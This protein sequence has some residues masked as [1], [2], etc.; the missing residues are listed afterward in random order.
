MKKLLGAV[1][2][3]LL[4]FAA[5]ANCN[6]RTFP[7]VTPWV[8]V[9]E[10]ESYPEA[11]LAPAASF[12]SAPDCYIPIDGDLVTYSARSVSVGYFSPYPRQNDILRI[13]FSIPYASKIYEMQYTQDGGHS[14][15]RY[16]RFSVSPCLNPGNRSAVAIDIPHKFV[17]CPGFFVRVVSSPFFYSEYSAPQ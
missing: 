3:A 4:V 14:W 16:V 6:I 1:C 9:N 12:P 15:H 8:T 13:I 5:Q 10:Y 11:F 2:V 7:P 17:N